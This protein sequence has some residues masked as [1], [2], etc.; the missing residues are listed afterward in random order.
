MSVVEHGLTR[1]V[2]LASDPKQVRGT[3]S[4]FLHFGFP[5][6]RH[7]DPL[8]ALT[9]LAHD[10]HAAMIVV[11]ERDDD[12]DH[13]ER[14]LE[15]ACAIPGRAVF[16]GVLD[17]SP[18]RLT[19]A[20]V[21]SGV[22]GFLP[23]P[24][25]PKTLHLALSA[26]PIIDSGSEVHFGDLVVHLDEQRISWKGTSLTLA[27]AEFTLLWHIARAYPDSVSLEMLAAAYGETQSD[28][29]ATVRQAI[30]RLR[31]KLREIDPAADFIQTVQF[32]G[33]TLSA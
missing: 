13:T 33:Y 18:R 32:A 14:L 20:A 19:T 28:R 8:E 25:T 26:Q 12:C 31:R 7:E 6:T 4:E 24:L 3:R 21:R 2:V 17:G 30:A 10:P 15:L 16:L 29:R 11:A 27:V 9:D 1:F 22:H 5:I 23:L